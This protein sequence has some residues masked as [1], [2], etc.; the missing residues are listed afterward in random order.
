MCISVFILNYLSPVI[1]RIRMWSCL[2]LLYKPHL[3][4]PTVRSEV[5]LVRGG[6]GYVV[7]F[8]GMSKELC[9]NGDVAVQYG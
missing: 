7:G 8:I 9:G 4:I 2:T 3:Y 6:G 1:L 5:T